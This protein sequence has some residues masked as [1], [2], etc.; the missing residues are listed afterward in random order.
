MRGTAQRPEVWFQ[1]AVANQKYFDACPKIYQD[2][3]D[4]IAK[5]TGRQYHLVEYYGPEDATHVLVVSGTGNNT[6]QEAVDYLNSKKGYKA[7]VIEVKLYRPWPHDYFVSKI[8]K[9]VKG[10]CVLDKTREDGGG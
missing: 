4:D 7:G 6:C 9:T 3:L 8:P 1:G 5:I 2:T 10:M